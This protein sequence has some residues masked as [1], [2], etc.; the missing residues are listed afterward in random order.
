MLLFLEEEEVEEEVFERF[1]G[2]MM[3]KNSLQVFLQ[4]MDQGQ[5]E[6]K[7]E[8]ISLQKHKRFA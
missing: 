4:R 8:K 7:T 6:E 1:L 2:L 5:Q 3:M